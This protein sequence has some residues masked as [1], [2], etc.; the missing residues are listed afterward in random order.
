LDAD[1]IIEEMQFASAMVIPSFI[2][3]CSTSM[4]EA[5]LIGVPLA[6][7][8][9]GGMPS[10]A[11]DEESALFFPMGDDAVCA[12]QLERLLTDKELTCRLSRQARQVAAHRNDPQRL[13]AR[14]LEIYRHVVLDGQGDLL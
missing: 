8:Y 9:A 12:F 11:Q 3:N 5:M 4:Q 2:E 6:V 10:I 7:S 1:Q 14:Q 13:I